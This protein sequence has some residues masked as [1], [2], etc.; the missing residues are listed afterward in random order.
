MEKTLTLSKSLIIDDPVSSNEYLKYKRI[1]YL[2]IGFFLCIFYIVF[3]IFY[4][5]QFDKEYV[6]ALNLITNITL[7]V[8]LI[9]ILLLSIKYTFFLHFIGTLL[10]INYLSLLVLYKF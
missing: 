1:H 5:L 4:A 3:L 10:L 9:L 8:I 6:T 7:L 2:V